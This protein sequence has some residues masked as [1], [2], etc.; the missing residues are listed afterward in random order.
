M[1]TDLAYNTSTDQIKHKV[2]NVIF[3]NVQLT[4]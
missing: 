1:L 2:N 3:K 4:L